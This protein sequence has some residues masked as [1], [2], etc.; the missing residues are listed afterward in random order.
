MSE[1]IAD[2][3][4]RLAPP[5]E[6]I[7]KNCHYIS[8]FL[9]KP[10]E[11][12]QRHLHFFDFASGQFDFEPSKHLFAEDFINSQAVEA[13]LSR[14]VERPLGI[15][16]ARLAAHDPTVLDD[17]WRFYRAAVLMVWL[18]GL[19]V[20][21]IVDEGARR[22]L[23]ELAAQM[24]GEAD[25]IVASVR[26]EFDLC[27][28]YTVGQDNKIAPV[29]VPSSGVFPLVYSDSGCLS[30]NSIGLGLPLEPYCALAVIPVDR[31]GKRDLSRIPPSISNFSIGR[32]TA[33]RV[34]VPPSVIEAY[35]EDELRTILL[36]TRATGDSL[37]EAF[38]ASRQI[39]LDAFASVGLRLE[40][41]MA[42]RLSTPR[43]RD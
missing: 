34:V 27:L 39:V 31:H 18:Q 12:Q 29:Y 22:N 8:Q 28:I 23:S 26:E 1:E 6:Q 3:T 33:S 11:G 17:D 40:Q 37:L 41:D 32:S 24:D 4:E 35:P 20:R 16:R 19:R 13:W 21:S 2:G 25:A 42:G 10:W 5:S 36:E 43:R 15:V 14:M 7:T 9:T 38:R 30:G